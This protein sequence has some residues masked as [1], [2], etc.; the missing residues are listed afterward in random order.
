MSQRRF[1]SPFFVAA[2]Q[3]GLGR[4]D[5]AFGALERA[6]EMRDGWILFVEHDPRFDALRTDARFAR[7]VAG[8]RAGV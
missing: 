2:V 6:L 1:V 8:M 7:L 3:V 5:E 4:S